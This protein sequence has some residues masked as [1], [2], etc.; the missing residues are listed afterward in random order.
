MSDHLTLHRNI[1][2]LNHH[3]SRH[4]HAVLLERMDRYEAIS[5]KL[6]HRPLDMGALLA[7][8]GPIINRMSVDGKMGRMAEKMSSITEVFGDSASPGGSDVERRALLDK[9][10]ML[11]AAIIEYAVA[12]ITKWLSRGRSAAEADLG[13]DDFS[14]SPTM[15]DLDEFDLENQLDPVTEVFGDSIASRL[16]QI[17]RTQ[18]SEDDFKTDNMPSPEKL[19]AAVSKM[20]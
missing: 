6:K 11:F 14:P 13:V 10:A 5:A 17:I 3:L 7:S 19:L 4:P 16:R 1:E 2:F 18:E 9:R 15:V 8:A 12:E 20:V